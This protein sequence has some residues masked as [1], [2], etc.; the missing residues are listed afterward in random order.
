MED[1]VKKILLSA[2]TGMV[3]SVVVP[4][5]HAANDAPSPASNDSAQAI[6]ADVLQFEKEFN[7]A[8]KSGNADRAIKFFSR[9][10][11]HDGRNKKMQDQYVALMLNS[12]PRYEM[13]LTSFKPITK[14]R[15][16]ITAN[17]TTSFGDMEKKPDY[18]IIRE[19]GQWRWM[20]NQKKSL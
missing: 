6:P 14:D 1:A 19:N 10:Y 11:L 2:F 18:Q 4:L 5:S 3:L 17:V 7:E 8:M 13:K 16:Y 12:S 20:G 15:A 9:R